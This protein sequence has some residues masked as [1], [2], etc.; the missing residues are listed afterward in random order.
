MNEVTPWCQMC[1]A[2]PDQY[3]PNPFP[4]GVGSDHWFDEIST[5][6][7]AHREKMRP[8]KGSV[9]SYAQ[10]RPVTSYP[11]L[12]GDIPVWVKVWV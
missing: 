11:V 6:K 5:K 9:K 12:S 10:I 8:H 4:V 2:L 3:D 1:L 7:R